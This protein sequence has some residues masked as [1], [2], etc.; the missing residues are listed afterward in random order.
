VRAPVRL[1]RLLLAVALAT[2]GS[3][4]LDPG[5]ARAATFSDIAD[6]KFRADIEWL[7]AAGI[8]KGCGDGKYC[9]DAVVTR[10]QMATFLV[11]MFGYTAQPASDPFSDDNGNIHE[12][13][14]N[15]LYASGITSGCA[16]G[17]FCPSAAVSRGQMATFLV[18]ALGLRH[19]AGNDYF[20]DDDGTT[21]E[22]NLDRLY[23]AGVTRGCGSADRVCPTS[24]VTR[25][26]M[27]AFLRRAA[28]PTPIAA[29]GITEAVTHATPLSVAV[30]GPARFRGVTFTTD[31]S[32]AS[33]ATTFGTIVPVT[34]KA[35][36]TQLVS[37]V[38]YARLIDGPMAGSWVKVDGTLVKAL[39]RAPAPPTCRYDDILTSRRAYDQHPITLLDPIYM[40]PSTYAPSDLRDTGS[41]ALNGGY[42]VRSVIG[43]DLAAMASAAR[44]AGAPLQVV[45]AYRSYA[46][47][48][49][50]FNYWVS[51][52]GYQQA[53]L[54]SA[55]PGHS[56]HQLGTT[57]DFTSE[58][59]AAPWNYADWAT[60]AAGSWM[61]SN[62]WQ[63]GFV[64]TY[65]KGE[66]AVT[67]YDYES[68]HYRY[69]GKPIA[70]A[71]RGSGMTLREAIWAA[72][73]P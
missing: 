30:S 58:G 73:G 32:A 41:Y 40:L 19:G 7:V 52:S 25:G 69:V 54:T 33:V 45:S 59:G 66:T 26:Q 71:V 47:Q 4:A 36:R 17:R 62:A 24:P 27:A 42:H 22:L 65:P 6:S 18:R 39:G 28:S 3:A 20:A 51:V 46:Q 10:G 70:A 1:L 21:H 68:W 64:M 67:C 50:T 48:E 12:P 72:Y 15:I 5:P 37:G 13:R 35:D 8:T 53:L 2:A 34:A 57:I 29:A 61:K 31:G 11:R 38:R 63:Y 56:E 16:P 60:T 14:I 9:P 23:F 44:A 43:A 55:R 49:A